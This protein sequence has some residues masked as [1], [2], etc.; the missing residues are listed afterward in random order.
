MRQIPKALVSARNTVIGIMLCLSAIPAAMAQDF[1]DGLTAYEEG[2]YAV[3]AQHWRI[4][5][6]KGDPRPQYRLG[7]MRH[8]GQGLKK[9]DIRAYMWL[10]LAADHGIRAAERLRDRISITMTQAEIDRALEMARQ[11]N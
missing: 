5:A 6:E 7:V 2:R 11:L 9:D 4:L 3:A 10:T 8:K 1:S